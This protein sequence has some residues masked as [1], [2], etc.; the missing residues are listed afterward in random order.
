M[1]IQDV[2]SHL[3]IAVAAWL[4]LV[5]VFLGPK[6]VTE[7]LEIFCGRFVA[8]LWQKCGR[9]SPKKLRLEHPTFPSIQK[10]WFTYSESSDSGYSEYVLL[11]FVAC[12]VKEMSD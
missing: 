6:E 12:V 11:V 4:L 1:P 3:L 9:F 2:I 10:T 5:V 8:D 7:V